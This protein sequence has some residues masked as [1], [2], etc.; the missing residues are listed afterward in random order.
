M[1]RW[2]RRRAALMALVTALTVS[3]GGF[4][5]A[6]APAAPATPSD[7]KAQ[8]VPGRADC[9]P[10][11]FERLRVPGARITGIRTAL[12]RGGKAQITPPSGTAVPDREF[13]EVEISLTHGQEGTQGL[14]ADNVH[15][16]VWL[17]QRWNGR[18]KAVGGGGTRAT[19]GAPSMTSA[20]K[21]GYAV[22]TSDA[23]LSVEN[24]RTNIFLSG[25]KFNWQLFE[26]WSYRSVH[27]NALLAKA[28]VQR[29]YRRPARYSYWQGCSNGGRQGLE[30]PQRFPGDFDGVLAEAPAIYGAE[31]LNMTMSWPAFLQNDAFGGFIPECKMTAMT[32]AVVKACDGADG[33]TDDLVGNPEGCDYRKALAAQIGRTLPCG[34]ITAR[35]AEVAAKIIEGPRTTSGQFVWYGYAPGVDLNNSR[36][37]D[38]WPIRNFLKHDPGYDWR[39]SNTDELINVF[40]PMYRSRLD[41]LS[42]SDP[43][44]EPFADRGGKLLMW[45]GLADGVFPA[46]QS[47]RYY[48]EVE[49]VSGKRT[50]DFFR[51]FL[52]PGVDHCGGG[53]GPKP[54]DPFSALV[55]WVEHGRAPQTLPAAATDAKGTVVRERALCP[56]PQVQV[57][58]GGDPDRPE[59]FRC[60]ASFPKTR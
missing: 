36:S 15:V 1:I 32:E 12:T 29:H 42:S 40:G 60:A 38:G 6:A 49:Q 37:F 13:C 22:T 50:G 19:Y 35:E 7:A 58:K 56:Y 53:T 39:T 8:P 3:A 10:Q 25:N 51:L 34:T 44:L 55:D 28:A 16:W 17:P 54:T 20:I 47:E 59:S 27:E 9:R 4:E 31:R 57:Y 43:V 24:P 26:N 41:I 48:K 21:A 23:G 46:A 18:I 33:V 14:P 30:M 2:R 11:R 52:A 45:H 5:A